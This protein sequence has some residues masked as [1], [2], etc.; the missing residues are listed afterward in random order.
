MRL[1]L[2]LLMRRL[3]L[4]LLL[5][6]GHA[7]LHAHEAGGRTAKR[8]GVAWRGPRLLMGKVTLLLL[9]LLRG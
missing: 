2:G 3:L 6:P 1:L 9:R 4:L 7:I 8:L 5:E